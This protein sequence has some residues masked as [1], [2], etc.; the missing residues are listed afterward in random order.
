M[1]TPVNFVPIV[2]MPKTKSGADL[3]K[4][5]LP[6]DHLLSACPPK[7]AWLFSTREAEAR[8]VENLNHKKLDEYV[9]IALDAY[10][11]GAAERARLIAA[12]GHL[13]GAVEKG[14]AA[15]VEAEL[16]R[17][18]LPRAMSRGAAR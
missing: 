10:R 8:K 17:G 4:T 15:E 11:D 6:R 18:P 2:R 16:H 3:T 12:F 1:L 5:E 13:F 7:P 14:H 9:G